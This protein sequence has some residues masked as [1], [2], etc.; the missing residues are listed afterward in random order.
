MWEG[1]GLVGW[2][3]QGDSQ[4]GLPLANSHSSLKVH[5]VVWEKPALRTTDLGIKQEA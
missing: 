5:L 2:A 3:K 4:L 1:R